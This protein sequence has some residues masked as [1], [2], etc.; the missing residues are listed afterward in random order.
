[1]WENLQFTIKG[2]D[3]DET[4]MNKAKHMNYQYDFL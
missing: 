3:G 2:N 4:Y 1:M